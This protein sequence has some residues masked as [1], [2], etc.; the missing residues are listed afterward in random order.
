MSTPYKFD[1]FVLQYYN[2]TKILDTLLTFG[3]YPRR[4][5]EST[6]GN[7]LGIIVNG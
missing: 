3:E 4:L 5:A 6:I 7:Q 1:L 2:N